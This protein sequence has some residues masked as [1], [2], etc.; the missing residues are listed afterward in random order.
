MTTQARKDFDAELAAWLEDV[1]LSQRDDVTE[2]DR[3]ADLWLANED[4][5]A[6]RDPRSEAARVEHEKI[7]G[8]LTSMGL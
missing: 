2:L 5:K 3:L 7:N 1:R 8:I 4:A 6:I